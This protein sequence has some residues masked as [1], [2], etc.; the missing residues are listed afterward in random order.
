MAAPSIVFTI[1]YAARRF[2][3]DIETIEDLA[4]QMTPELGCLSVIEST[5]EMAESVT[6]FTSLGLRYLED[7]LDECRSEFMRGV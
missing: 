4:E 6:A 3:V 2:R 7:L 1:G 5:D